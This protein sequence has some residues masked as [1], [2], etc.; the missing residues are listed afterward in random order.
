MKAPESFPSLEKSPETIDVSAATVASELHPEWNEDSL[1]VRKEQ[2]FFGILDGVGGEAAGG[3]ASAEASKYIVSKLE[4][5]KDNST[6]PEMHDDLRKAVEGANSHILS[7]GSQ[8]PELRGM[9]TTA[10]VAKI[11]NGSKGER[12]VAV[13]NIGDSRAY[14]VKPDGTMLQITLDDNAIKRDAG[15]K[16]WEVQKKLNETTD[17]GLLNEQE[18]GFFKIRHQIDY[19]GVDNNIKVATH[20]ARMSAGDSILLVSDGVSDNLTDTEMG[21]ILASS[22][23]TDQA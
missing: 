7:L 10:C 18:L 17:I 12:H 21:H 3:V 6:L 16:A 23:N 13:A 22:E 1:F 5:L 4:T 11:V 14:R 8:N 9:G 19:L 20:T 2:E 15:D